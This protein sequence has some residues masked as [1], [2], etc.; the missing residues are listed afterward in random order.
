MDILQKQLE[1]IEQLMQN[2]LASSS[3]SSQGAVAG[4]ASAQDVSNGT[5]LTSSP[6]LTESSSDSPRNMADGTADLLPVLN[7]YPKLYQKLPHPLVSLLK[8]LPTVEGKD[9]NCLCEFLLLSLRVVQRV[10][11]KVPTIYE[12]LCPFCK[13]EVLVLLLQALSERHSF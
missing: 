13:G 6:P 9:V 2:I 11:V 4:S 1:N 5:Y 10:Q 8:N 12:N 7:F 3:S